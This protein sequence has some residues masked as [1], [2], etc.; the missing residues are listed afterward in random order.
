MSH[1]MF[2]SNSTSPRKMKMVEC[3]TKALKFFSLLASHFTV[4]FRTTTH[5]YVQADRKSVV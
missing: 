1:V 3:I 4:L 5:L 2:C